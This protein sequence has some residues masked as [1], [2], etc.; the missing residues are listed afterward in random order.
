MPKPIPIS[1]VPI[2]IKSNQ[3]FTPKPGASQRIEFN[4]A[5]Q[6]FWIIG[7]FCTFMFEAMIAVFKKTVN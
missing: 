1:V 4:I 7:F 2:K 5:P 6:N 3:R